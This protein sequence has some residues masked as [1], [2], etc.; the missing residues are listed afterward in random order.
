MIQEISQGNLLKFTNSKNKCFSRGTSMGTNKSVSQKGRNSWF[1]CTQPGS[2]IDYAN[3]SKGITQKLHSFDASAMAASRASRN[4]KNIFRFVRGR[5]S[6]SPLVPRPGTNF[7]SGS[8][9]ALFSGTW[10]LEPQN[11]VFLQ[12]KF[13]VDDGEGVETARRARQISK[14]IYPRH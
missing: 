8:S 9:S 4:Y 1:A 13:V 3:G 2:G 6:C 11:S 14:V 7:L 10:A 5:A 12:T